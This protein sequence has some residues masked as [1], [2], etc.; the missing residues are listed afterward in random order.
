MYLIT[1][2]EP[3]GFA[4]NADAPL[5]VVAPPTARPPMPPPLP[6][7]VPAPP[8]A[9]EQA[10]QVLPSPQLVPAQ[11]ATVKARDALGNQSTRT[12][13]FTLKAGAKRSQLV[14]A[15]R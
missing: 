12:F 14:A 6:A 7:V 11:Q 1:K 5:E 9:P 4:V 10:V 8:P 3:D 2:R 13:A 15:T